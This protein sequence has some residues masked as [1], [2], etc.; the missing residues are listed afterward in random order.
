ML[1]MLLQLLFLAAGA[2]LL[3][4]LLDIRFIQV[5]LLAALSGAFLWQLAALRH[6]RRGGAAQLVTPVP[7][8]E[9]V[10]MSAAAF[11]G[12]WISITIGG[13]VALENVSGPLSAL[14]VAALPLAMLVT[15]HLGSNP[16]MSGSLLG[17]LLLPLTP[18]EHH[19][20]LALA[21]LAGWGIAAS[22][23]PFTGSVLLAARMIE[24][25]PLVPT[26][27]WNGAFC[28]GS[29]L[30][31]G[32]D[33]SRRRCRADAASARQLPGVPVADQNAGAVPPPAASAG[34]GVPGWRRGRRPARSNGNSTAP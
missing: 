31:A 21:L 24:R 11:L 27:R 20:H 13:Q 4:W 19:F 25:S 14:L 26:M 28:L 17:G 7:S 32:W 18:P 2:W 34:P 9:I 10:I 16:I 3:E 15:G 22:G 8:N 33:S 12:K 6:R 23:T 29:A 5:I 30:V 1:R